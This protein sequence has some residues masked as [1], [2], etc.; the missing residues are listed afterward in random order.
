[1]DRVPIYLDVFGRTRH[2][3]LVWPDPMADHARANH[4]TH[5]FVVMAVPDKQRRTRTSPAI[6]FEI[7]LLAVSRNFNL[8]LQDAGGPEHAHHVRLLGLPEAD[9][10]VRRV[11]A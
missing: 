1:M 7:R 3:A 10:Q 2:V 9:G 6:E 5:Q 8:I 11:L 4:V